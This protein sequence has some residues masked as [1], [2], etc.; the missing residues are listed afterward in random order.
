VE[1]ADKVAY[2]PGDLDILSQAFY[3]ALDSLERTAGDPE[4]IKAILMT[5][6]L[7]AARSG[8][9]DPERL[10]AAGEHALLL[11][12]GARTDAVRRSAPI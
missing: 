3:G 9:R 2:G 4:E 1:K 12:E 11:H 10:Q 6:I 5:G 7:D 8:E